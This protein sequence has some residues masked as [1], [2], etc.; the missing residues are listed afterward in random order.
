MLS[1][2]YFSRKLSVR[3]IPKIGRTV[4]KPT[5]SNAELKRVSNSMYIKFFCPFLL[6]SLKVFLMIVII[7]FFLDIRIT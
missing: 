4:A 2:G 5:K 7:V 6:R 3:I 1:K